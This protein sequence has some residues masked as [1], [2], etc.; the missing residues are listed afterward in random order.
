MRGRIRNESGVLAIQGFFASTIFAL[1]L[2]DPLSAILLQSS[3]SKLAKEKGNFSLFVTLSA[4]ENRNPSKFDSKKAPEST[5]IRTK[6]LNLFCPDLNLFCP[7][8]NL[9]CFK[10]IKF[11][12]NLF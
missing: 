5:S 3:L 12:P 6:T 8:L 2:L 11:C 4:Y 1:Q 9:F 7:G 10:L